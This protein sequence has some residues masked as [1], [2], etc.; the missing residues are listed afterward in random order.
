MAGYVQDD[1]LMQA[2]DGGCDRMCVDGFDI[3]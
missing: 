3:V 1:L 2:V